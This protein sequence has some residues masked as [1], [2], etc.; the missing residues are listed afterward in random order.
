M[1]K[2]IDILFRQRVT[3]GVDDFNQPIYED[4]VKTIQNVLIAPST[5]DDIVTSTNLTG[6]KAVYTLAI[7]KGDTNI[8]QDA[9]VEFF[10]KKWRVF[11]APT[12][13]IDGLIPLSW[14]KKV[15]VEHYEV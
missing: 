4:E 11:T 15:M 12:Q 10:G 7:P 6:K 1:L 8:W 2:G 9:I 5:S 3:V 14:N 13:G